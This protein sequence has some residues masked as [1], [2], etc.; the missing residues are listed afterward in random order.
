MR[1]N[2]LLTLYFSNHEPDAISARFMELLA[3]CDILVVENGSCD[4]TEDYRTDLLNSLS[5]GT[6]TLTQLDAIGDPQNIFKGFEHMLGK[7]IHGKKK[8]IV[9]ENS[10]WDDYLGYRFLTFLTAP[11][12]AHSLNEAL[13]KMG[14]NL[15]E[16]ATLVRQRDEA[17]T[18]QLSE[19]AKANSAAEILAMMG[20]GHQ[21]TLVHYLNEKQVTFN[22]TEQQSSLPSTYRSIALE[23]TE[24][25]EALT[26]LDL[27]RCLAEFF[28]RRSFT[29]F[30][31]NEGN[32]LMRF[33]IEK[34]TE[35]ALDSFLSQIYSRPKPTQQHSPVNSENGET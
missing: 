30:G 26:R 33:W 34:L 14:S 28:P 3:K 20:S 17:Y 13:G 22:T 21:R 23:R 10:P 15:N 1:G 8:R 16:A 35:S 31:E 27:L 18:T 9:L 25:H 6:L 2:V 5:S 7:V 24:N 19:L 29:R 4:G 12:K 32:L 11:P